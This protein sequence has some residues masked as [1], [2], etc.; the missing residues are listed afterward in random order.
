MHDPDINYFSLSFC[1][2]SLAS[3]NVEIE[4]DLFSR[5]SQ[6]C[7]SK[8]SNFIDTLK[9]ETTSRLIKVRAL[10]THRFNPETTSGLISIY[11]LLNNDCFTY[12]STIYNDSRTS[13]GKMMYQYICETTRY[14]FLSFSLSICN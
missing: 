11:L 4:L 9:N 1:S 10:L 5:I 13:L 12:R 7:P 8:P 6:G 2:N 14:L 3:Q